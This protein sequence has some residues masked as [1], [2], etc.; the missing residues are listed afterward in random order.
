MLVNL[1]IPQPHFNQHNIH[2]HLNT[3]ALYL[4][5]YMPV[6]LTAINMVIL[7]TIKMSILG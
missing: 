7:E 3:N 1:N 5:R 2:S 6:F 4:Y